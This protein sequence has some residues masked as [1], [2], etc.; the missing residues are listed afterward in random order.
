MATDAVNFLGA[1]ENPWG[2]EIAG[3]SGEI[4]I[5]RK[6]FAIKW[7]KALDNGGL[8]L[9]DEVKLDVQLDRGGQKPVVIALAGHYLNQPLARKQALTNKNN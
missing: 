7:N 5:N 4:K 6:D 1:G 2:K 3:F 9:G 8:L